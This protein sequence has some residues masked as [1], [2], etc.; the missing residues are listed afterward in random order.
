MHFTQPGK[1]NNSWWYSIPQFLMD[2]LHL[3]SLGN[4]TASPQQQCKPLHSQVY[5]Q[6]HR[7]L[8]LSL[9]HKHLSLSLWLTWASHPTAP[10]HHSQPFSPHYSTYYT[11]AHI[12]QWQPALQYSCTAASVAQTR[13]P[14]TAVAKPL[15][16]EVANPPQTTKVTPDTKLPSNTCTKSLV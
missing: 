9:I 5:T 6:S 16:C 11:P 7:I 1:G 13:G 12:L 8:P 3:S 4:H 2:I 14:S 10:L 15:A